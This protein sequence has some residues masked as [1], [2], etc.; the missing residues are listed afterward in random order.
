MKDKLY[1]NV[2]LE[3]LVK[4]KQ[5]TV[6]KFVTNELLEYYNDVYTGDGFVFAKGTY[7]VL[8]VA[9]MDTVHKE[10]VKKIKY[11][12]PVIS[13]PQGIGGDDRCGIYLILELIKEYRCSVVFTEDEECGC[14]GAGKF[15]KSECSDMCENIKYIVEF[16]RR[17]N[18]DAV[19]YQCDNPDFEKFVQST[20]YFKKAWGSCSDISII[21][22]ALKIAAVNLS[23]GYH[24]EHTKN[25]TINLV[26]V[27]TIL[28]EAKKLIALEVEEP[29]IY[30]EKSYGGRWNSWYDDDDYW[31]YNRYGSKKEDETIDK[32][33]T[34]Y[35]TFLCS[36]EKNLAKKI[37]HIYIDDPL[38]GFQ[39]CVEIFAFNENEAVGIALKHFDYCCYED[40]AQIINSSEYRINQTGK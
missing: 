13:S 24:S 6:K 33:Y 27:Q 2:L 8:L 17:G 39:E 14:I 18:K 30:I 19:F 10:V 31:Y 12:G 15:T 21:A 3:N 23:S 5:S 11:D 4:M 9:H 22:P 37:F 28:E 7:P 40:I 26:E 16:D 32:G 29:Y 34:D 38:T 25:E 36:S 1:R 35:N 20:G